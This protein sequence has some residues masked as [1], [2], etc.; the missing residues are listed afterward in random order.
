MSLD[1]L[2]D[3]LLSSSVEVE[4]EIIINPENKKKA[5]FNRFSERKMFNFKS[6]FDVA[7]EKTIKGSTFSFKANKCSCNK[8]CSQKKALLK[9]FFN[10]LS[11]NVKM[12]KHQIIEVI[13]E[14]YQDKP[15]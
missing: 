3:F 7:S 11:S 2:K 5:P 15:N 12:N 8:T 10:R 4:K 14:I 6:K 1:L 13:R 9:L